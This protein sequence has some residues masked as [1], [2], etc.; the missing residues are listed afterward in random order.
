MEE[1]QHSSQ[2][3]ATTETV[4]MSP[5]ST[6]ET[7]GGPEYIT[8]VGYLPFAEARK[9]AVSLKLKTRK[10]WRC[11]VKGELPD[12]PPKPANVPAHPDGIYKVKGWQ[13]WRYWLGTVEAGGGAPSHPL[14]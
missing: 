2:S 4:G 13:G 8:P 3:V 7:P 9:F 6:G 12:M 14:H 10:E 1:S 11:Y 5:V